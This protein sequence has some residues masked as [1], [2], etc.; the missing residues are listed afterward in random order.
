MRRRGVHITSRKTGPEAMNHWLF[1]FRPGRCRRLN[2]YAAEGRLKARMWPPTRPFDRTAQGAHIR[3]AEAAAFCCRNARPACFGG[4]GNDWLANRTLLGRTA[5][6]VPA[7]CIF[8][9]FRKFLRTARPPAGRRSLAHILQM[10]GQ[11]KIVDGP[12]RCRSAR[13]GAY[14]PPPLPSVSRQA[15][16]VKPTPLPNRRPPIWSSFLS[17]LSLSLYSCFLRIPFS[18]FCKS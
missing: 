1:A 13:S 4:S 14:S 16:E 3:Y 15:K 2:I 12:R 11:V 17:C 9:A 6:F 10:P 8:C 18:K 5:E 7:D